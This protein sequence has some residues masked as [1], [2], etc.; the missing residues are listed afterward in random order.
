MHGN[1]KQIGSAAIRFVHEIDRTN[2]C[3]QTNYAT[4]DQDIP[5]QKVCYLRFIKQTYSFG[6]I[7]VP[8][9]LHAATFF[10][11]NCIIWD[12]HSVMVY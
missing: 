10:D 2:F 11:K 4:G 8:T 6:N 7:H 5:W 9:Y 12:H 3:T 1:N